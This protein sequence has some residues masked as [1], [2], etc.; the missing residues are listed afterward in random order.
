MTC[1]VVFAAK[2]LGT[3]LAQKVLLVRWGNLYV[4]Q[5]SESSMEVWSSRDDGLENDKVIQPSPVGG[6]GGPLKD[7]CS[8]T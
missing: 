4:A 8:F 5:V 1:Q 3:V 2:S 7:T 6:R